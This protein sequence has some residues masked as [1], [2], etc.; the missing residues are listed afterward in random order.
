MNDKNKN[1]KNDELQHSD[2]G[3]GNDIETRNFKI[4]L[5]IISQFVHPFDNQI[6]INIIS[7]VI[8]FVNNYHK[9]GGIIKTDIRYYKY[10]KK[11]KNK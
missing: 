2:I 4:T 10:Y 8:L 3:N 6:S 7:F 5:S 1:L 11:F 9:I